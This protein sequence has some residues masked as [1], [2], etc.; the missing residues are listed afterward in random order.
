LL[1]RHDLLDRLPDLRKL[2]FKVGEQMGLHGQ[3]RRLVS[4]ATM[5]AG[6]AR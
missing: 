6:T 2:H 1:L 3:R 4:L 5:M